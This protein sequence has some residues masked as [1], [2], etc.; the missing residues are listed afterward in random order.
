MTNS[1]GWTYL[2][3]DSDLVF[4]H[5]IGSKTF[6]VQVTHECLGDVFGSDGTRE[7]DEKAL[8]TNM[9]QIARIATAKALAGAE[10]PLLVTNSDF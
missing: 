9:S 3:R 1:F 4:H 2:R 10:S 5:Q 8:S 7:G 6:Q